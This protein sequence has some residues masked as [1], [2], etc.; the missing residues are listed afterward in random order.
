MVLGTV[1]PEPWLS[2]AHWASSSEGTENPGCVH[3]ALGERS[4]YLAY[5]SL[6]GCRGCGSVA[7]LLI[8]H[9]VSQY[10]G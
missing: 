4:V 1:S 7:H 10:L 2:P 3:Q 8:V 9:F 6:K 5:S